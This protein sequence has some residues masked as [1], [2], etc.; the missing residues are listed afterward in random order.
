MSKSWYPIIDEAKCTE[1]GACVEKCSHKVYHKALAPKPVV[2]FPEGCI[3][4]CTGCATLC[5]TGAIRY[6]G[7]A[8]DREPGGGCCG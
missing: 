4:G 5:P 7:D 6:F 2:N 3:T 1:C 8:G